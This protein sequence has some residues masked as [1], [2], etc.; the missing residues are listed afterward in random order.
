[1]VFVFGHM[2]KNCVS[3]NGSAKHDHFLST[4]KWV[5]QLGP[6]QQPDVMGLSAR[7]YRVKPTNDCEGPP[8]MSST[9][10]RALDYRDLAD[11]SLATLRVDPSGRKNSG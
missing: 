4:K 3:T 8:P 9:I 1:M 10:D 5:P 11:F 7:F 6:R 2:F